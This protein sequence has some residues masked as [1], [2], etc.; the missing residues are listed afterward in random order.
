MAGTRKDVAEAIMALTYVEM[1]EM[2]GS[3]AVSIH[4]DQDDEELKFD[5]TSED[6]IASRLRW[7]AENYLDASEYEAK[8][9]ASN[10]N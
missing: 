9:E 7:W 6:Q 4:E 5:P 1:M 2:A 10:E 8:R 3:I